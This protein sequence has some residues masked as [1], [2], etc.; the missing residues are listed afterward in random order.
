MRRIWTMLAT[1]LLVSAVSVSAFAQSAV[2]LT[3]PVANRS[4]IADPC[5]LSVH[6]F[7]PINIAAAANTKIIP[8]ASGKKTYLCAL[9][10]DAGSANNIAIIE[11]SGTNCG[12]SPLGL[13]GGATAAAGLILAANQLAALIGG[14]YAIAGATVAANDVC[15][16]TSGSGQV[17]GVAVS[18]QQ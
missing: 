7:I 1:A 2:R 15:L 6:S 14:S 17:T 4:Y 13:L 12:T 3:D 10:L 8:G 9:I 16:V 18:V 11:G 5:Q